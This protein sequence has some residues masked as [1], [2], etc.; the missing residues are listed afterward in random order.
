M[1]VMSGVSAASTMRPCDKLL[2]A[3]KVQMIAEN[4]ILIPGGAI[5]SGQLQ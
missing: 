5:V 1:V 2:S 3:I 4:F